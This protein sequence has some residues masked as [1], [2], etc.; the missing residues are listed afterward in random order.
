MSKNI[1]ITLIIILIAA[2]LLLIV[3]KPAMQAPLE[4]VN[5]SPA[6]EDTNIPDNTGGAGYTMPAGG[7]TLAA[8]LG[9]TIL[10][11]EVSG[12]VIE[13]LEDSRCPSDVQCIQ[14]GT[15]RVKANFT[16]GTLSQ[17]LTLKLGEPVTFS[18][19]SVTLTDVKPAKISTIEI[20]PSD[21]IFTFE[22]K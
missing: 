19:Y 8:K 9:E 10:F 17:D 1:L 20:R 18:G 12:K 6:G 22:V 3:Y 21:Y 7:T 2:A 14:A 5:P 16:F 13:V 4:N 11:S 15:V